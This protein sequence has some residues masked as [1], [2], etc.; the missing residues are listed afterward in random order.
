M[1]WVDGED[2]KRLLQRRGRLAPG[3][4]VALATQLGGAL[5]AIHRAGMIHRDVKP[6]NVLVRDLVG[7]DHSY[8]ADFGLAKI[9]A[10]SEDSTSTGW[11]VGTPGYMSP[12]QIDGGR[13]GPPA[14]LYALGCVLF[15]MLAGEPPFSADNKMALL[16]AHANAPRPKPS[17]AVPSLGTRYDRFM[18]VA[19]ARDPERR[20]SSAQD[21]V[22]Q[23]ELAHR[24]G[25]PP[26]PPPAPTRRMTA[27]APP[28]AERRPPDRRP[29]WRTLLLLALAA[30]AGL[31]VLATGVFSPGTSSPRQ[32]A[33][34]SGIAG[35]RRQATPGS[36][37]TPL[38]PCA[39]G[40]SAGPHTSCEFARNVE[41]AYAASGTAAHPD[42]SVVAASPVTGLTYRLS[43]VVHAAIVN[44][45]GGNEAS[46]TFPLRAVAVH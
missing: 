33:S 42:V 13:P 6:A 38:T 28:A 2:L 24:G 40:L 37:S 34:G 27:V 21:F 18:S 7:V 10:P 12:E 17:S 22:E 35:R 25:D 5:G 41:R 9:A 31:I 45:T 20:F 16:L 39:P 23:L 8:L 43:C 15:E 26:A 3:E 30:A 46:I 36:A 4:A 44:C 1:Q 14:D 32:V 11:V 29:A 19:L